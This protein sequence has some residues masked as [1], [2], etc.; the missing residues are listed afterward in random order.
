MEIQPNRKVVINDVPIPEPG[1]GQFLIK[2]K[3]ASLCHSDL[4]VDMKPEELSPMTLGHECVGEIEK[5]HPSCA[6]KEFNVG[7][8]VGMLYIVDC[9]FECEACDAHGSQ[10]TNPPL[11]SGPKIKGLTTDGFFAEYSTIDWENVIHLPDNMP[12]EK[13]SPVFCAG[14]TGEMS[15]KIALKVW[16]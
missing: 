3:A 6:D 10:C 1:E 2:V 16:C 8:R 4:M 7:D 13:M 9:C 14:I 5:I 12:M 15:A 11:P